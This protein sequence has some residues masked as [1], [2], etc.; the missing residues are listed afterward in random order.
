MHTLPFCTQVLPPPPSS[1]L[2]TCRTSALAPITRALHHFHLHSNQFVLGTRQLILQS[3]KL[4]CFG[5]HLWVTT[6]AQSHWA[7]WRGGLRRTEGNVEH[8][9]LQCNRAPQNPGN[10]EKGGM[11]SSSPCYPFLGLCLSFPK[12]RMQVMGSTSEGHLIK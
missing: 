11:R 6:R 10:Q 12:R 3:T 4:R 9:V 2:Q 5:Q 7:R 8:S 1:S